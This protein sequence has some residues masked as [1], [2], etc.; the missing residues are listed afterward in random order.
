LPFPA[1]S[2][3]SSS[4]TESLADIVSIF[5]IDLIDLRSQRF[6]HIHNSSTLLP[7][8]SELLGSI[9][10]AICNLEKFISTR[11]GLSKL[12]CKQENI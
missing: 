12:F 11:K 3:V 9:S 8:R 2:Q 7:S 10:H 4:N 5:Q 6:N 1:L